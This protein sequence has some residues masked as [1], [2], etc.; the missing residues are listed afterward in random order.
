MYNS[1]WYSNLIK[2]AFTPPAAIFSPVWIFLYATL[3]VSLI[4]FSV[5]P[6]YENK[7]S[8]Y[9][10]FVTQMLLNLIWSPVFFYFKNIGLAFII[11]ILLD[12]FVILT[13]KRFFTVSKTAAV[14]LFPY[15]IWISFATYLNTG[16]FI[17]NR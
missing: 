12:I 3:L 6:A 8:G 9:L 10:C 15:L 1:Y 4:L 2:P 5:K 14:I 7:L 17:L 16:F 11:I 13:I